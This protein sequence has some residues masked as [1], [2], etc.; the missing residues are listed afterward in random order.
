MSIANVNVTPMRLAPGDR[1]LVEVFHTI[2][3]KQREA[4]RRSVRQWA[5]ENV[6]VLVI[7]RTQM[8]LEIEGR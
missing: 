8:R 4:I 7:D 5:G 1:L 6:E 3:S 2:D